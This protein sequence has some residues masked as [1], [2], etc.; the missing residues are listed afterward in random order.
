[1]YAAVITCSDIAFAVSWLAHFL[2]N[3]ESLH[4]VITDQILLYLKRYWNLSLQLSEDDEY[5]MTSD[6][7][8]ANNTANHKSFQNYA[9]KLFESL[10][11]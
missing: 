2:M 7:S 4:Q 1:M 3:S 8:F 5:I 9:M 11:E 6:V 10:V